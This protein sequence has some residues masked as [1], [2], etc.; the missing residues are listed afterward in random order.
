MGFTWI[1]LIASLLMTVVFNKTYADCFNDL[2]LDDG[3]PR[4]V[5]FGDDHLAGLSAVLY[6]VHQRLVRQ[7]NHGW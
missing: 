2:C 1:V 7:T 4:C 3:A 5:V 6:S